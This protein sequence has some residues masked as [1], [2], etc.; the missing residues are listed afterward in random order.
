M[1]EVVKDS[2]L[3]APCALAPRA[4]FLPLSL[5]LCSLLITIVPTP[6]TT[7]AHDPDETTMPEFGPELDFD[8]SELCVAAS[9]LGCR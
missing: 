1:N 4:D 2:L 8:E 9:R 6:V 7:D 5:Q 3:L